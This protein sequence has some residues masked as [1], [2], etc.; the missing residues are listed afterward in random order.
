MRN[1]N[2]SV[3]SYLRHFFDEMTFHTGLA[4]CAIMYRSYRAYFISPHI[5]STLI[6]YAA[7][8]QRKASV[9]SRVVGI[10]ISSVVAGP[11]L[12]KKRQENPLD[13]SNSMWIY[14]LTAKQH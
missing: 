12:S 9:V 11:A 1:L 6:K 13:S 3:L 10:V 14:F 4:P 7:F 5:F 8:V 2:Y